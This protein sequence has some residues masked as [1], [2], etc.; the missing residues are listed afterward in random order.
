MRK[1][2]HMNIRK[3]EEDLRLGIINK[4]RTLEKGFEVFSASY[5]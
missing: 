3:E 1:H 2:I 4:V 5:L